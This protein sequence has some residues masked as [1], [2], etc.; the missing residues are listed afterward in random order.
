M[1]QVY[2]KAKLSASTD[3]K[4]IK[5]AAT[6]SPGTT[7]HT[8]VS[9]TSSLD[10]IWLYAYNSHTADVV[11]TI[12]WGGTTSPDDETIITV[13]TKAGRYLVVDG[14]LLQNSLVVKCY[15]ATTNVILIDGF[16]NQIV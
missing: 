15:A 6:S 16:V 14:Q 4:K 1:S 9:G 11:L 7:V 8:A 12:Q 3:G 10:E 13:P 5:V 2:S